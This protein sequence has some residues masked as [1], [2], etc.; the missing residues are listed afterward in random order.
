MRC[1]S[2][3]DIGVW[4][5]CGVSSQEKAT[6]FQEKFPHSAFLLHLPDGESS[7]HKALLDLPGDPVASLHFD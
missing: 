1:R 4:L 3:G 5:I 6:A 2:D 7:C